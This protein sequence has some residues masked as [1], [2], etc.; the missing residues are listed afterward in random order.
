MAARAPCSGQELIELEAFSCLK[1]SIRKFLLEERACL[2]LPCTHPQIIANCELYFNNGSVRNQCLRTLI[3]QIAVSAHASTW[4]WVSH[5]HLV[6]LSPG[7]TTLGR[8]R[9]N[10]EG[11]S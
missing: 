2:N 9:V 3:E 7:R 6:V 5:C 10:G 1:Q 8:G 11:S 4:D